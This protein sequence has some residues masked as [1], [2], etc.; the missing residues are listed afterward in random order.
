MTSNDVIALILLY[1]TEFYSFADLLRHN[2][3]R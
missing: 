1:F 2:V 3:W